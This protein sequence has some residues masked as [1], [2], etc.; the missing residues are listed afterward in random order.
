MKI[1]IK[2][3]LKDFLII[4]S[5]EIILPEL[6]EIVLESTNSK[7]FVKDGILY[8]KETKE[9]LYIPY[10]LKGDVEVLDGVKV[11]K[12]FDGRSLI[13]KITI[14]ESVEVIETNS[15]KNCTSLKE[16]V[17]NANITK[18]PSQMFLNCKSQTSK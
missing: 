12:R 2:A 7:L 9:M 13:T 8:N 17:I 3:D 11:L 18:L 10:M 5:D 16:A 4:E 14:P 1:I 6:E 15:F